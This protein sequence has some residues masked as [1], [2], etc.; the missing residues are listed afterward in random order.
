[1]STQTLVSSAQR[2]F[3]TRTIHGAFGPDPS[4]GAI[5]TPIHQT[6]TFVQEAVGVHKGY[7]Y[8]RSG[9]PTVAALEK[10][11]GELES[12]PPAVAFS[13]GMS[14]ISALFLGLLEQGDRVLVSDVV[15]GGTVRLLRSTTRCCHRYSSARSSW[16]PTSSS[17]RRRSTSAATA[18]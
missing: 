5:L 16:A 4:T 12:A 15:Y 13:T 9:N 1:M 6:T 18:T 2:S 3:A 14:A 8:T 17:T 10:A 7:T 11:L